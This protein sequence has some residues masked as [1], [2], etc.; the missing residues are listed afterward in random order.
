MLRTPARRVC[1]RLISRSIS[2][3]SPF[4]QAVDLTGIAHMLEFLK[5]LNAVEHGGPVRH[6]AA[7]PA[8]GNIRHS[9]A[10][11]FFG[12]G[13]LCLAFGTQS[14]DM[15]TIFLSLALMLSMAIH[16]AQ[17][18]TVKVHYIHR[19]TE[20]DARIFEAQPSEDGHLRQ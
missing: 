5:F 4:G 17:P 18:D 12:N 2:N 3:P 8:L 1:R 9:T 14:T 7:Q 15:K 6:H 11:G 16:A 10:D 13:F 19:L 20:D